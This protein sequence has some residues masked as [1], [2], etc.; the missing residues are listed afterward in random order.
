[1]ERID[2]SNPDAWVAIEQGGYQPTFHNTKPLRGSGISTGFGKGI[3]MED[4]LNPPTR[5]IPRS[6]EEEEEEEHIQKSAY[7]MFNAGVHNHYMDMRIN[8]SS[9]RV[10][11]TRTAQ[12][13]LL[14]IFLLVYVTSRIGGQGW[15][16]FDLFDSIF[17]GIMTIL[18]LYEFLK[19]IATPVRFNYKTQEVYAYHQGALYRIPW[20]ECQ[21]TCMYA[22]HFM[23]VG[24][25]AEAYNLNLWLYP[26]Y[27]VKGKVPTQP[28]AL[29]LRTEIEDH[30]PNYNYWEYIRCFMESGPD[31]VFH[32]ER[33]Y[34]H[35]MGW[36][37][38]N[39]SLAKRLMFLPL[40]ILVLAIF[41]PARLYLWLN[42]F[43]IKWPKEVHEWTGEV[44]NWH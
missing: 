9:N 7:S 17:L 35:S 25:L 20:N 24:G 12:I 30:T 10:T 5:K 36:D 43:K 2:K 15:L 44:R 11:L 42:P 39:T 23:G 6:E 40:T 31:A 13:I 16:E 33:K 38:E 34:P 41:A 29:I 28:V 26:E 14:P 32:K 37:I 19:P 3:V 8:S 18:I 22:P 27:C 21:I 4:V 1:M